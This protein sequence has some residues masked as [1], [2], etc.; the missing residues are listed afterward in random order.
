MEYKVE[1]GD[2]LSQLAI[3]NNTTVDELVK[4]NNIDDPDKIFEG[5][6]LTLSKTKDVIEPI[7]EEPIE[8]VKEKPITETSNFWGSLT[9]D[10]DTIRKL[11]I[12]PNRKVTKAE[13]ESFGL[14]QEVFSNVP[15]RGQIAIMANVRQEAGASFN[16]DVYG[17]GGEYS[18]LQLLG[19]HKR[20][21]EAWTG[22]EKLNPKDAKTQ[23]EYLYHILFSDDHFV[24]S[25]KE[26]FPRPWAA[27]IIE[28]FNGDS[29]EFA[30]DTLRE[31]FFRPKKGKGY[32][33]SKTNRTHFSNFYYNKFKP[34]TMTG[35]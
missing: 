34:S 5:Q 18:L 2:T 13:K 17:K 29:H 27:T 35:I 19:Y 6:V 7:K 14:I 10:A 3:D 21:F 31:E 9:P 15:Y 33:H 22:R 24:N 12:N 20:N 28:S 23:L 8:V 1:Y 26:N 16:P 30:T 4:I 32:E 25:S 11:G